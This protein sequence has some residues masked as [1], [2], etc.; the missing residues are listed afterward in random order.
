MN[1]TRLLAAQEHHG[2]HRSDHEQDRGCATEQKPRVTAGGRESFARCLF[3]WP[4]QDAGNDEW[5]H[6]DVATA[7]KVAED[8]ETE[9]DLQGEHV[10][11]LHVDRRKGQ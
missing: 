8:A 3:Q 10:R 6:L 1:A 11:L 2:R 7:E 9:G 5:E 4:C